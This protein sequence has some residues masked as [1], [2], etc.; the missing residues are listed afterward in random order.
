MD[1][2]GGGFTACLLQREAALGYVIGVGHVIFRRRYAATL[3]TTYLSFVA[4]SLVV[5]RVR[6]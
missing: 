2:S 5:A 1:T 6:S 3:V 4:L